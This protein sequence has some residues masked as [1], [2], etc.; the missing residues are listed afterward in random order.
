MTAQ[1]KRPPGRPPE[2]RPC[3][4]CGLILTGR[5]MLAH[6]CGKPLGGAK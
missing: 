3:P 4:K 1:P 5:E 6:K 2:P